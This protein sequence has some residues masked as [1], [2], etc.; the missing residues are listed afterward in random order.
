M[1]QG[2]KVGLDWVSFLGDTGLQGVLEEKSNLRFME[3]VG[4]V[5]VLKYLDLGSSPA[6]F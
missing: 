4:I 6:Y 1:K 2:I 3:E 5:L